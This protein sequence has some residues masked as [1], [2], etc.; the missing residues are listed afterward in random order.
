MC[1]HTLLAYAG[2]HGKS[3]AIDSAPIQRHRDKDIL[4]TNS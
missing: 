3:L 2:G 1:A 4:S